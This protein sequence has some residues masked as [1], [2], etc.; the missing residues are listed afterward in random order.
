MFQRRDDS[1]AK[2]LKSQENE[3]VVP[4]LSQNFSH[5]HPLIILKTKEIHLNSSKRMEKSSLS[6]YN[7][8]RNVFAHAVIMMV[9]MTTTEKKKTEMNS[10]PIRN[11]FVTENLYNCVAFGHRML[12]TTI[13]YVRY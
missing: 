10:N 6:P 9:M 12:P 3:K 13:R 1:P 8:C 7:T 11:M 4:T 2:N 5:V